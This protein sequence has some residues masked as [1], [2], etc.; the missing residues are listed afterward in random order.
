MKSLKSALPVFY[1][2]IA[3]FGIMVTSSAQKPA[4]TGPTV[5]AMIDSQD[6]VFQAQNVTPMSGRQR[7]LTSDYTVSVSRD[8][9][10]SDLPYF[11]RA[12]S[13]PINTTDGGIKFVST[14]FDYKL[15]PR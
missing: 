8:T 15:Q 11:G 5:K 14:D 6:Y 4:A 9:V 1:S 2:I 7:F 3:L 10:D 12:Y 13:A